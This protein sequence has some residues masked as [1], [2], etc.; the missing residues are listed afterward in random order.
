MS[1]DP[2]K[3]RPFTGAPVSLHV[4]VLGTGTMGQGI[5]QVCAQSGH[6]TR[7]FDAVDGRALGAVKG[8]G[9]QLEKLLGKGK[10]TGDQRHQAMNRLSAATDAKDACSAHAPPVTDSCT[11]PLVEGR[12]HAYNN[13]M[14]KCFGPQ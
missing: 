13:Y 11:S 12:H 3:T 4:T 7:L 5:A 6:T 1:A 2:G 9:A 8:I 10:I 14:L